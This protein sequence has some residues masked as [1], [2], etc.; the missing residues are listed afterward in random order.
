MKT[1]VR[2]PPPQA[3]LLLNSRLRPPSPETP[4]L[5]FKWHLPEDR[6]PNPNPDAP[7]SRRGVHPA[8]DQAPANTNPLPQWGHA[9]AITQ[10][11]P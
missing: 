10:G 6:V 9:T 8:T 5:T 11:V 1:G 3:L 7:W 4:H 2:K